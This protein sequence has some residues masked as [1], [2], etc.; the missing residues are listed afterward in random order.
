[1]TRRELAVYAQEQAALHALWARTTV[2][3]WQRIH[4]Q[5]QAAI[6]AERARWYAQ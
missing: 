6:W 4:W 3:R 1:M 2:S 5:Q